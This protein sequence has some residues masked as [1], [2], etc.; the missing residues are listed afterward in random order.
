[1]DIF[2]TRKTSLTS[3]RILAFSCLQE[4][5]ILCSDASQ[6]A[7]GAVLAQVQ[8]GM[9]KAICYAPKAL[10]KS[11]TENSATRRE[12]LAI[13]T[14]TRHFRDYLLGRKFTIYRALQWL[15]NFKDP[16]R[17]TARWLEKLAAFDYTFLHKPG[18]SIG[19]ADGLSRV[20]F[21]EIKVVPQNSSG[22]ECPHQDESDQWE[23]S[24]M[25]QKNDDDHASISSEEWPNRE[26]PRNTQL[27]PDILSAPIRYQKVI[28][29][30]FYS[31]DSLAHC[32]SADFKISTDI[33]RKIRRNFS[34]NCP[35]NLDHRLNPLWPQWIPSQKKCVHQLITKQKFHNKPTFGTLRASLERLRTHAEENGVRQISMPCIDSV[36]D[37]LQWNVVRQLIQ[38]T[39]RTSPVAII[40][41]LKKELRSE[42]S[43]QSTATSNP[44][45]KAQ[46]AHES[47]RHV[48][49]RIQ[50]GFT[51]RHNELQ[52]LP[53]PGWQKYNQMTSLYL[54]GDV[55]CHKFEPLDG[56]EPYF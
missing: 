48:R 17:M 49:E 42:P 55:L 46:Q 11:Q 14:F 10:S 47:L 13:V 50:K 5:F 23:H 51:P 44:V 39:F 19:Y 31:T 7:M 20:P 21:H 53:R 6:F 38:D 34:M 1:M 3:T 33:A 52:G 15:Q 54:Q 9:E 43:P 12:L 29:D 22:I 16:D 30:V 40:V 41:Y 2:E 28:G 32:V 36:L 45:V 8:D 4:L 26:I 27:S 18:T 35:I 24:T 25:T 37:K 56:S